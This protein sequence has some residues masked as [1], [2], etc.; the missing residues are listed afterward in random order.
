MSVTHYKQTPDGD[1]VEMTPEEVQ[2]SFDKGERER[3]RKAKEKGHYCDE[4]PQHYGFED[5][6]SGRW[7]HGW[8]CSIC[9]ELI[10]TG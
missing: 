8:E 5:E 2:A 4:N 7:Y 1:W 9:G 3:Q 10:H 6:E